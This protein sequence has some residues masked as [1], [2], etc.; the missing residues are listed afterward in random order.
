MKRADRPTAFDTDV[1]V[2]GA[3]PTGL[4]LARELRSLGVSVQLVDR[5][6]D[7]VHESRAMAIQ[8]RTLEVLARN[9]L[10]DDL[11]AAG[12]TSRTV[13][14][15]D[16]SVWRNGRWRTELLKAGPALA[17]WERR[18]RS[19]GAESRRRRR[20]RH[21]HVVPLFDDAASDTRYPFLLFLSQATT[22]Q[23]LVER[24]ASTGTGVRRGVSLTSLVQDAEGVTCTL[25]SP[26]TPTRTVRARY[27]VGCDGAHGTTRGLAGISFPGRTF[28]ERFILAD[29]EVDGVEPDSVHAFLA[30]AGPL[31]LF[32]LGTPA[33]WRLIMPLPPDAPS[34]EVTL[35][36]LQAAVSGYTRERLVLH[37]PVWLTEFAVSSRMARTFQRGRVFLAGDAAHIHSPAGGQGMNTGIQDAVNL[38]WK[39][40]LVCHGDADAALLQS[41]SRERVPVAR[42][43]LATTERA[44]G[45]ATS[46]RLLLRKV[47][48]GLFAGTAALLLRLRPV[49]R[50]GFRVISQLNIRYPDSPLSV[51]GPHR[52]R[53]GPRPGDRFPHA[54]A[55]AAVDSLA[56]AAAHRP[57]PVTAVFRML[58][59]GP[60]EDWPHAA[61]EKFQADWAH[62]VAVERTDT[63]PSSRWRA[64]GRAT[65]RPGTL[66]PG[67]LW[68]GGRA[69]TAQY[70]VRWDGYIGYRE[71]GTDLHGAAAYLRSLGARPHP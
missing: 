2:I 47:R 33:A 57:P 29:L 59:C 17:N 46:R 64:A 31:F 21:T 7:A 25:D 44:F 49:R 36:L 70:L 69:E 62:L 48:A 66:W 60:E 34:G 6:P 20:A 1:L 65:L 3:G 68:P 51:E 8:A 4:A 71:A 32:P 52:P 15:H 19:Q 55:A 9:Q 18:G 53:Q 42:A 28:T 38:G 24:L 54:P 50:A 14:L 45:L 10:A 13:V 58:L 37:Q 43:V 11:I 41:Y 5:A 16:N 67:T 35:P 27:L 12:R 40:A 39:L 22:E 56:A 26:G 30:E 61:V 63:A 23:V